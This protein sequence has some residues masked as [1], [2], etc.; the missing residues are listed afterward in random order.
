MEIKKLNFFL[1]LCNTRKK[2]DKFMKINKIRNKYIID[3]KLLMT[4]NEMSYNEAIS[5]DLFKVQ[6]LKK[7]NLAKEKNKDI[8]YIPYIEKTEEKI[9]NIKN[10][11]SSTHNFNLL[12]FHDDI[13]TKNINVILNK[14]EEFDFTQILKDY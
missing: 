12:F 2:L 5:S 4:E 3:L 1:V 8:Y 7:I 11:I 13:Q 6:I 14:I 10:I 9:F